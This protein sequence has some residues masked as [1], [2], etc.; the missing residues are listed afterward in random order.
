MIIISLR[1]TAPLAEVDAHLDAHVAWLKTAI[2]DGWVVIAGRQV[3]REG[4]ILI[5]RGEKQD[6]AAKAATD[7]FVIN[8][9]AE[10][11]LVEFSPSMTAPG[12]EIFKT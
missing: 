7:P 3:P 9:V 10:L 4:G 5:A 12:F 6:V 1:Y 8:N 2:A 11:S